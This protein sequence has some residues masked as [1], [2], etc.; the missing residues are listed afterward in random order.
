MKLYITTTKIKLPSAIFCKI[1]FAC[2]W[3]ADVHTAFE[4]VWRTSAAVACA[5]RLVFHT[6]LQLENK[7]HFSREKDATDNCQII[8]QKN[9]DRTGKKE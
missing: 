1:T 7:S 5:V 2:R 6:A 4:R 9:K 8:E 3:T